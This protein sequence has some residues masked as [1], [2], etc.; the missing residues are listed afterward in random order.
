MVP[1]SN[2]GSRPCGDYRRLNDATVPD[3][4]PTPHIQDFSARLAGKN[5]FSKID[6]VGGYHQIPVDLEDVPKTAVITT[7]GSWEIL[8]MP[9]VLKCAAQ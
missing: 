5:I 3:R 8:R 2:G 9:F 6:F 4:Y 1:E 7:F